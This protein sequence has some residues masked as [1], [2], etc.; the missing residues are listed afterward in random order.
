MVPY[1]SFLM[2]CDRR[3]CL[4]KTEVVSEGLL[5]EPAEVGVTLGGVVC[6]EVGVV[7]SGV[8]SLARLGDVEDGVGLEEIT[9]Q[10]VFVCVCVCVCVYLTGTGFSM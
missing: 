2:S 3:G 9:V 10:V 1:L 4:V 7:T 8:D 5:V 6:V